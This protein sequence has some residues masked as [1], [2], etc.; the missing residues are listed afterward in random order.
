MDGLIMGE[1]S[2]QMAIR[3]ILVEI[4]LLSYYYQKN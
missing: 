3:N 4:K 1:I 2:I